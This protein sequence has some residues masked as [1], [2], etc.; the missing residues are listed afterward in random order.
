MCSD[1]TKQICLW[2]T[3]YIYIWLNDEDRPNFLKTFFTFV[4][5][6]SLLDDGL[7]KVGKRSGLIHLP[8]SLKR[9]K[10]RLLRRVSIILSN[11]FKRVNTAYTYT[12]THTHTP[13]HTRTHPHT[14]IHPTHTHLH[15]HTPHTPTHTHTP[16]TPTHTH[17]RLHT[18]TPTHTH[19]HT[20]QH[21]HPHLHTPTPTH[22][23]IYIYI[24]GN[25]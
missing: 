22:I 9:T 2:M 7:W 6:P 23:Y 25:A 13:T 17:T 20:H 5:S 24:W 11:L 14:H 16:Y 3:I 15:T 19:L 4:T 8:G 12:H 18:H 10:K 21:T 1:R